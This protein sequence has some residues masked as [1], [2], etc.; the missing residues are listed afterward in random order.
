[1]EEIFTNIYEKKEWGDNAIVEYCGSSGEGSS[2]SYNKNTYIPFLKKFIVDNNIKN[3]VDFGCGDFVCGSLIYDDLDILY[4]GY[5]VYESVIEYNKKKYP[6]TK[7][8]FI[9]L[10]FCNEKENIINGDMCIL[11]DVLQ[12]WSLDN[13][14]SF[15]D[16]LVESNKFKYIL[17]C[18]CCNQKEDNTS[19]KNGEFMYLNSKYLPL[20]KYNP[21]VV[22]E[23]NTKEVSI[24]ERKSTF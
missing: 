4:T 24:I 23:Y 9:H 8:S 3:I 10:D 18:N 2:I 16:Y 17:I 7:Y 12:H 5:D 19:I 11:K 1:M 14:Y 22:Y 13:I 20:K 21:L 6:S 15:L